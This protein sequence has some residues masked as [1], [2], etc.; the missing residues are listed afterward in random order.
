MTRIRIGTRASSLAMVQAEIV[1]GLIRKAHPESKVELVSVTTKGDRLP[2]EK[3]AEV[4]GKGAFTEDLEA[5]LAKGVV[6]IA[7]HSMKDLP[8]QL[9]SGLLIAATPVRGDPRDSLVSRNGAGL[10]S[11]REGATIGTSSIRRKAQ[12]RALRKDLEVFDLHGNVDTRLRRM[13]ELGIDGI[14]IAAAG[15]ERLGLADRISQYF[16]VNE[17]VPAPCQGTIALEAREGDQATLRFLD[18]VDKKDVR[19]VSICERA[20]A[21]R[22]GGDCD[23][24]AG[25]H[26][27]LEGRRLKLV[28]AVLSSDG[29]TVVKHTAEVPASDPD[30]A[31]ADFADDVLSLGGRQI[32]EAVSN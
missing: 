3:R 23:V 31:G 4:E 2:L 16:D 14:V 19:T 32:L 13:N 8:M 30:K 29:G 26:A 9:G 18:T 21:T 28:G 22:L 25:F 27:S 15:L 11:L 1:A 20:F 7:V 17:L 10:P 12:L 24:P 5:Q 6:D